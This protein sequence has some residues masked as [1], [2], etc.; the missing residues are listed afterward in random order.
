MICIFFFYHFELNTNKNK[1]STNPTNQSTHRATRRHTINDQLP[2]LFFFFF[3]F[4][5]ES[6][7]LIEGP[8]I[9]RSRSWMAG[10]EFTWK[11][12]SRYR[13]LSDVY[14]LLVQNSARYPM[15]QHSGRVEAYGSS[16]TL[17]ATCCKI[18][19][20]NSRRLQ[21]DRHVP[22]LWHWLSRCLG[23][24]MHCLGTCVWELIGVLKVG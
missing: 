1:K 13:Y 6:R 23:I 20:A 4:F 8:L 17:L 9:V 3:F 16:R 5:Y 7:S 2:G 12:K 19:Y 21:R 15:P 24:A 22:M 18:Q 10:S 14:V 11:I